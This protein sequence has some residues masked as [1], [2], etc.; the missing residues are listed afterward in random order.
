V[1]ALGAGT[2]GAAPI[3]VSATQTEVT[4]GGLRCGT[5]YRV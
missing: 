2:T 1:V 3:S 5:E 4:I